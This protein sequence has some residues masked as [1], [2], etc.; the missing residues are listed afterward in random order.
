MALH[1]GRTSSASVAVVVEDEDEPAVEYY[2]GQRV[3]P[4]SSPKHRQP[5]AASAEWQTKA[6]EKQLAEAAAKAQAAA[7]A[8]EAAHRA[9]HEAARLAKLKKWTCA[10]CETAGNTGAACA[11]CGGD[12]PRQSSIFGCRRSQRDEGADNARLPAYLPV[13]SHA[14]GSFAIHRTDRSSGAPGG[15][16]G[17]AALEQPTEYVVLGAHQ[18]GLHARMR[19]G[20]RGGDGGGQQ[21]RVFIVRPRK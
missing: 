10:S 3:T 5:E 18:G 9:A 15:Y 1:A 8:E 13:K 4:V 20:G 6:A 11:L 2:L 17:A 14:D 21:Q 19:L 7:I 12:R 16:P